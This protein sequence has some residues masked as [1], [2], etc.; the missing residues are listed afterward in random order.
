MDIY[1]ISD[2]AILKKHSRA[3]ITK[4]LRYIKPT[5]LLLRGKNRAFLGYKLE[6][7]ERAEKEYLNNILNSKP[8]ILNY[9]IRSML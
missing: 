8:Y 6:D 7:Y 9:K 4:V 3:Y 2:L 5:N 1:T